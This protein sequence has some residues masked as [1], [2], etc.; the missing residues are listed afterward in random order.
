[1]VV[2]RSQVRLCV[3]SKKPVGFFCPQCKLHLYSVG[4]GETN[5]ALEQP[6][7]SWTMES[8]PTVGLH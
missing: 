1:M 3:K 4:R 6:V 7:P 5:D 2:V 8:F